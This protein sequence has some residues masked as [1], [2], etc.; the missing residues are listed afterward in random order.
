MKHEM[1]VTLVVF[2]RT[3]M[4]LSKTL[5]GNIDQYIDEHLV[6]DLHRSEY[7]EDDA[8]GFSRISRRRVELEREYVQQ[9]RHQTAFSMIGLTEKSLEDAIR[10]GKSFA[11]RLF[12]LID[13]RGLNDV[14]VYKRANLDRKVFSSIR[15]KKHYTPKKTTAL[16]LALALELDLPA[17]SDL[18]SR[19]G[20]A[21]DPS[22]RA[23]LIVSY[24][25]T[26]RQYDIITINEALFEYGE[27]TLGSK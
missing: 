23:D 6:E 19:A 24:F 4:T 22:S 25:I 16:A 3:A 17:V 20:Y 12:E 8:D 1:K 18:L 21:L 9:H 27:P 26:Q 5:M 10:G 11:D 15:C 14:D 13:E 2:D 7:D